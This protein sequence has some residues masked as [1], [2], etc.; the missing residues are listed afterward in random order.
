[1]PI[2]SVTPTTGG[3]P[4]SMEVPDG[5]HESTDPT[6]TARIREL[7]VDELDQRWEEA[8]AAI[9]AGL[10]TAGVLDETASSHTRLRALREL[11]REQINEHVLEPT[12]IA[13][14]KRGNH[15]TA[16]YVTD[17]FEQANTRIE[18]L[19]LEVGYD[20]QTIRQALIRTR[21]DQ[22]IEREQRADLYQS[23]LD[24]RETTVTAIVEQARRVIND[25]EDGEQ[26]PADAAV[27]APVP[28]TVEE[29]VQQRGEKVGQTRSD[30]T[31]ITAIVALVNL[32]AI[33][34]YRNAGVEFVGGAPERASAAQQRRNRQHV[35]ATDDGDTT[36]TE[37]ARGIARA[38][39]G[40]GTVESPTP[41]RTPP[42]EPVEYG[43]W[44]TAGD[45]RVCVLCR[46]LHGR[47]YRLD[48]V[49]DGRAPRP[50]LHAN[51]RC[52]LIPVRRV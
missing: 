22:S 14:V 26:Q 36:L 33:H 38:V 3:G 49:A 24:I 13:A 19:L 7:L 41:G 37:D 47:V 6:R 15:W 44:K 23:L 52:L 11:A 31:A 25:V 39:P 48:A 18:E 30:T 50:P 5:I 17:A 32:F 9:V 40:A 12:S 4:Q 10:G 34:T 27:P 1:M 51:C 8:I 2:V 42:D 35:H 16:T 45:N 28:A 43:V 21:T 46:P 20:E 29:A